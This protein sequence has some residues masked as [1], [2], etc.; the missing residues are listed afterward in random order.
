MK[1]RRDFLIDAAS[2]SVAAVF[3]TLL[4]ARSA[5]GAGIAATLRLHTEKV[6]ANMPDDFVG[7]S[8]ES[9]Q[10]GEPD[11]FSPKNTS[12]IA[13]FKLL[14]PNGVLRLGGNSSEFTWWKADAS[15]QEPTL[16]HPPGTTDANWMPHVLVPITPAA[17]DNLADFLDATGWKLIYGLNLGSGTP[18]RD[19]EEA[20][21][22][23]KAIGARLLYF[24]I[25][26]EPDLYH[27]G[28]NG[29]RPPD[30][31]FS[32]YLDNWVSFANGVSD[33]LSDAT[34]GG[35]DAAAMMDWALL[36]A[37]QAPR[38]KSGIVALTS[39]YYA[40]GPPDDPNVTI[41]RLLRRD[42]RL[43]TDFP[44]VMA[45]ARAANL[46]YRMTEGNSCF[47]GGKPNMS[48]AFASSLWAADYMLYLAQ[49]GCVGVNLHGGGTKQIRA[50]L[51]GHLPGESV[52]TRPDAAASGSF[53]T[54]I[55]GDEKNGF[56]PR[57]IFYG[58]M[59]ASHF[60]GASIVA[61]DFDPQGANAT[62]YAARTSDGLTIAL[63]NKDAARDLEIDLTID[64][65]AAAQAKRGRVWRLS[66]P[67]LE[68]TSGV[69]LGGAKVAA[70]GSWSAA[71]QEKLSP[72][73][74]KFTVSVPHASGALVL[75]S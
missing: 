65:D 39:H 22:V 30:W 41:E 28:R 27:N 53:Y 63:L 12:L 47:R 33:K 35:P 71:G 16:Q 68:A 6:L 52:A 49:A 5:S 25:G 17:I 59:L 48:D 42:P 34:F 38:K 37:P 7:L 56:F 29:L 61:N 20:V 8:Y 64:G 62:A 72:R 11:F 4:P 23:Y 73:G 54:P 50:A 69:T 75:L 58:M 14:S 19:S 31:G 10:L 60:A 74:G 32:D 40:E 13:L 1:N 24:Q 45:A 43:A 51:G 3:S 66:G 46:P 57:P 70:N 21:Y 67:A 2:A 55:A 18:Q 44:R 36:F 9:S 26:N 15:A